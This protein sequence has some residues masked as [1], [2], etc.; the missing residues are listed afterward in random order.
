MFI[1]AGAIRLL[2]YQ[3]FVSVIF[4]APLVVPRAEGGTFCFA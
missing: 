1:A 3:I 4:D 2:V